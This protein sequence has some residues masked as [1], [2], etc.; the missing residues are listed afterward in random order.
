MLGEDP[1]IILANIQRLVALLESTGD[2]AVRVK[3]RRLLAETE[4]EYALLRVL[5]RN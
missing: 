5:K 3:A 1:R 4:A 2:S